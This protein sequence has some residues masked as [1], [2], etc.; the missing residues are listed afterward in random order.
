[1][2]KNIFA[3]SLISLLSLSSFA[4]EFYTSTPQ[5]AKTGIV[6]VPIAQMSSPESVTTYLND[7]KT[8][9]YSLKESNEVKQMINANQS[10]YSAEMSNSSDPQD[11]HMK[12]SLSNIQLAFKYKGIPF[13]NAIG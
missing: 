12:S 6:I 1:M 13:I 11:T 5:N 7:Q 9:G 3:I 4:D 2:K 10:K 8:K